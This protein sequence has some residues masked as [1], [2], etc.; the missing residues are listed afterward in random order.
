MKTGG[1]A[2]TRA[3]DLKMTIDKLLI[4]K[5]ILKKHEIV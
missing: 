2:I 3:L 5:F 4:F 1:D